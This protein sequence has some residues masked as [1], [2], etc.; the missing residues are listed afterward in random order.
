MNEM[1]TKFI[2]LAVVDQLKYSEIEEQLGIATSV[3]APWWEEFK[4]YRE[5]I[6]TIRRKYKSKVK[7]AFDRESF[8]KFYHWYKTKGSA[9]HYCHITQAEINDLFKADK[10]FTKRQNT[11]G[12]SL[13]IERLKPNLSYSDTDNLV[14]CCY[15]CNNA[16][17]DEFSEE[18]F[19]PIGEAIRKVW[20][21]RL[22]K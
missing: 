15:W 11:R 20:L 21:K 14:S 17:T 4:E 2:H 18:E 7:E 22:N 3:F 16:K 12:K 13:G 10:I 9:C 1:Q 8:F 6:S 5:E 19:K